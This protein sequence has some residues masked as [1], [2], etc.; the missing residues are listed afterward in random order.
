[1]VLRLVVFV[2]LYSAC[3]KLGGNGSREMFYSCSEVLEKRQR[4]GRDNAVSPGS[5]RGHRDSVDVLRYVE[6]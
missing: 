3:A 5:L 1:M 2:Q 6:S 4:L